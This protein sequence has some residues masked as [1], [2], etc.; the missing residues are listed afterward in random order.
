MP[1]RPISSKNTKK[2]IQK[3]VVINRLNKLKFICFVNKFFLTIRSKRFVVSF[4]LNSAIHL[5][6][7]RD[8]S[9]INF[10]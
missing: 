6:N 5:R 10:I 8:V 1:N 4:K 7:R 3:N 9:P 2:N